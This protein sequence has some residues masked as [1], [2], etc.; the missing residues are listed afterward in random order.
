MS[1]KNGKAGS[2]VSPAE[3]QQALEADKANPGEVEKVKAE[4]KQTQD[5][6]YGTQSLKPNK[7]PETKEEKELKNSWL[8]FEMVDGDNKPVT[9]VA[10]RVILSDGA[11]AAEGTLDEKGFARLEGIEPGSC[12]ITFPDLDQDAWEAL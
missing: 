5:G 11:T 9:G 6:K 1:P 10:Y 2:A 12:K 3:A 8:E 7:P 4:Q